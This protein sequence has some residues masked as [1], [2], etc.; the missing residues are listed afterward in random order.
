MSLL[1]PETR[2]SGNPSMIQRTLIL[3]VPTD[4]SFWR[5][6][7]SHGWCTLQPFFL[8]RPR[9]GCCECCS[10]FPNRL[11]SR[12]RNKTMAEFVSGYALRVR[13]ATRT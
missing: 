8:N 7:L 11:W 10:L 2:P 9:G 3:D 12:C 1:R 5:T 4:F 13:S 6:V